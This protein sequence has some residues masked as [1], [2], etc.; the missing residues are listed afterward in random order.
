MLTVSLYL[1]VF[2][3]AASNVSN[4]IYHKLS[5]K[6]IPLLLAKRKA[7]LKKINESYEYIERMAAEEAHWR[8][9]NLD[10]P[11]GDVGDTYWDEHEKREYYCC[12]HY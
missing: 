1:A 6:N 10:A 12:P 7:W 9:V 8:D 5:K 4:S 2:L 11:M 3:W